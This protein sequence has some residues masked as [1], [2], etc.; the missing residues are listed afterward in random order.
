M[1]EAKKTRALLPRHL[2][3]QHHE[4]HRHWARRGALGLGQK[5]EGGHA[6]LRLRTEANPLRLRARRCPPPSLPLVVV[7]VVVVVQ[8]LT[9]F[10]APNEVIFLMALSPLW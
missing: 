10:P 4:K 8:I 7:A 6:G 2:P 5:E 9:F 3:L 1:P